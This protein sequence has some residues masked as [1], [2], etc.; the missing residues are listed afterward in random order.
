[1]AL[2]QRLA[3]VNYN[4]YV[5]AKKKSEGKEKAAHDKAK[6]AIE[7]AKK[8]NAE[9]KAAFIKAGGERKASSEIIAAMPEAQ[10]A[11]D[12]ADEK[13]AEARA[14]WKPLDNERQAYLDF[15]RGL[16]MHVARV[17]IALTCKADPECYAKSL[18]AKPEDITARLGKYVKTLGDW[19]EADKKALVPVQIERAMLE[20]GKLGAKAEG[21]TGKLL[22]AAKSNDRLTRQSIL[23][24]LP[25]VAKLPCTSCEDKL[26]AAIKAGEGAATL[27]ELNIETQMLRNYFSWAGK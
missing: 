20:L 10:T 16:E 27:G 24:A 23:L 6:S 17:E 3:T 1:V 14:E 15:T 21:Q 12:A 2:L 26:D 13:Y 7:K 5:D 11:V 9:A 8:K 18:T 19:S 25:K 22:D 4:K